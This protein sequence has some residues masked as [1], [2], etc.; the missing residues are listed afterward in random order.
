MEKKKF[1]VLDFVIL[2]IIILCVAALAVRYINTHRTSEKEMGKYAVTF[3]VKNVRSTTADAFLAGDT[4]YLASNDAEIGVL[5]S[6][7]SNRPA[8]VYKSDLNGGIVKLYYPEN[9]LVDLTA[10][11]SCRGIMNEN[12]FFVLGTQYLSPG[13]ELTVYTPHMYVNIAVTGI[14]E[15]PD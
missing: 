3:T 6:L 13:T 8:S 7:D 12:G 14:N 9:T 15:I 2:T 11:F 5:E 4:V 1:N 10:T